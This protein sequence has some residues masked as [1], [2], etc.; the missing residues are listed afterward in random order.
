M[1]KS[2]KIFGACLVL[3]G[4]FTGVCLMIAN[5]S[6]D[7]ASLEYAYKSGVLMGAAIAECGIGALMI[8]IF[9]KK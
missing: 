2:V 1:E 8:N 5:H 9:G 6:V 4:L 7:N 3:L